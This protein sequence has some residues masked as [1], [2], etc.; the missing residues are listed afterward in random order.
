M[1]TY[2]DFYNAYQHT[3]PNIQEVIDSEQIGEFVDT[4]ISSV[5]NEPPVKQKLIV[6]ISNLLVGLEQKENIEK[7]LSETIGS[8]TQT[9][10]I[11]TKINGFLK[12]VSESDNPKQADSTLQQEINNL[13]QTVSRL[14]PIRTMTR[15]MGHSPDNDVTYS[16][17]SQSDLLTRPKNDFDTTRWETDTN[18]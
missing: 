15:D 13:E 2:T 8:T 11:A 16:S 17:S 3:S 4:L 7:V 5:P 10:V 1:N 18:E 12:K 14:E 9:E 6:L